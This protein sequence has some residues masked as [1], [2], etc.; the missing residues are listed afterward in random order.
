LFT[1][2]KT[3]SGLLSFTFY[4]LL[5]NPAAYARAQQEVDN[6][7]GNTTITAIHLARLPYLSAVLRKSLQLSL[8][9]PAIALTAKENT[10]LSSKY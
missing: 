2:Y 4:Y 1:S 3:T 9:I 6:I 7:L 10:T 8:T 5:S